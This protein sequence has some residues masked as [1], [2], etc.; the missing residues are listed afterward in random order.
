V[1]GSK[2]NGRK[3]VMANAGDSRAILAYEENGKL[4][5]CRGVSYS[6]GGEDL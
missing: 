5:V 1:L 3:I 6:V 2:E 4:K